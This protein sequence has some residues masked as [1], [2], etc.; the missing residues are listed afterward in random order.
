MKSPPVIGIILLLG[1]APALAEWVREDSGPPDDGRTGIVRQ[2]ATMMR[3]GLMVASVEQTSVGPR[4]TGPVPSPASQ[5]RVL[6][7]RWGTA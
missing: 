6:I 1:I 7:S 4:S 2:M 5:R 3:S